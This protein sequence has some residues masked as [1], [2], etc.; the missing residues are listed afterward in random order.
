MAMLLF[1][2]GENRFAIDHRAIMRV[3]PNIILK[4]TELGKS[5]LAGIM[6]FSGDLIPIIDF[7]QLIEKRD[8]RPFLDTRIILLGNSERKVGILGEK[9]GEIVSL[10]EEDFSNFDL[11]LHDFPFLDKAVGDAQGIIQHINIEAFF[12]FLSSEKVYHES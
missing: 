9:V 5:F 6:N 2:V 3:V 4:K 12:H 7:S 1:Y 8:S 11:N 10:S